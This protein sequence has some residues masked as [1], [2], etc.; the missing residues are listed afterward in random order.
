MLVYEGGLA[1]IFN[2]I[3]IENE[4]KG[5]EE[6]GIIEKSIVGASVEYKTSHGCAL[7]DD[8][9]R[10]QTCAPY[11]FPSKVFDSIFI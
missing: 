6:V 3:S 4:N 2:R 7:D 10:L 9:V 5:A 11:I 1:W 8:S